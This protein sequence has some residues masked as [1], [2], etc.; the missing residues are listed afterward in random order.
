MSELHKPA[1]ARIRLQPGSLPQARRWAQYIS[2][3]RS[4]ALQ[5][6]RAEG[7]TIESVFLESSEAGDFLVYYMRSESQKK[8]D[9]VAA[10][11]VA[12]I[13]RYHQQFKRETWVSATRL[14]L[15]LDLELEPVTPY[16]TGD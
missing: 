14:E 5:T 1:C 12:D 10:R 2:E 13:D 15:L 16:Q 3:H 8:A 4:E 11:S 7:V 9:A 6:L